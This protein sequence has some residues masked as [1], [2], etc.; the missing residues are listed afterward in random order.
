MKQPWFRDGERVNCAGAYP[1]NGKNLVWVVFRNVKL[2][3]CVGWE[4]LFGSDFFPEQIECV[5]LIM[6]SENRGCGEARAATC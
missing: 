6:I 1:I 2:Q 3:S 5:N 4:D